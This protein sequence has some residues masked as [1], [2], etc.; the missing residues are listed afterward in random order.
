MNKT[1]QAGNEIGDKREINAASSR[2]AGTRLT[3]A[4]TKVPFFCGLV[5]FPSFIIAHEFGH[6]L[7]SLC[8]GLKTKLHFAETTYTGLQQQLT[9]TVNLVITAAGVMAGVLLMAVGYVWLWMRR[10]HRR[11]EPVT[12]LDWLATSLAMN[13]GRWLR[14]LTGPPSNPQPNDE[15]FISKALGLPSWLLPYCLTLV[16]LIALV[17]IVREHPS[18]QRLLPFSAIMFGGFIGCALWM[19]LIGPM[20]LP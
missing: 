3:S 1:A 6:A 14:G 19:W 17:A 9:P 20:L 13:A 7:T 15:A 5:L 11:S 4:T 8:F 2:A 18:G 12:L 16:A 10:R